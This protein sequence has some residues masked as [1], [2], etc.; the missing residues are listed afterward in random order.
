MTADPH[1][2]PTRRA[3]VGFRTPPLTDEQI[4][5]R[6]LDRAATWRK[7]WLTRCYSRRLITF[8]QVAF[9]FYVYGLRGA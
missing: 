2:D 7:R 8:E 1:G 3:P 9:W 6:L 5:A 4:E